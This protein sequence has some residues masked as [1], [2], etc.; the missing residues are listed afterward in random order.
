MAQRISI[1]KLLVLQNSSLLEIQNFL[2][3]NSWVLY[4]AVTP[5]QTDSIFLKIK[6]INL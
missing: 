2:D 6:Y 1:K 5:A 4:K 3:T